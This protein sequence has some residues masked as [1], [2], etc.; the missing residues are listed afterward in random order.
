MLELLNRHETLRI[1]Q[2]QTHLL[3]RSEALSW[4]GLLALL[5]QRRHL[6][7]GIVNIYEFVI[8][9]LEDEPIKAA[10]RLILHEEFP[11][12]TKGV[13]LPSHRELLFQDLVSLGAT[14]D[15]IL[16]TEGSAVTR[17]VRHA[18]QQQLMRC[19]GEPHQ[20]LALVCFLRFWAEVLVSVEYSCLWP[21]LSQRLS[22]GQTSERKKSEFFYYHMIHDSRQS[23]IGTDTL[24][25]G[26]THAQELAR[27]IGR[28]IP[29]ER[30]LTCAMHQ[31]DQACALKSRFYDQFE[32]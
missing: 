13:A 18:S 22:H 8:D 14:R 32:V 19:L 5:I 29:D 15:Q 26:L 2:F 12:N 30:G 7:L 17:G 24:L 27:L 4:D 10:V 11:R 9:A 6:S 28:L 3:S 1:A 20:Q 31:V 25:G 21:R 23:D 16:T